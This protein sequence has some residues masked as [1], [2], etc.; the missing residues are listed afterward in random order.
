M[1]INLVTVVDIPHL[2][3]YALQELKRNFILK[4]LL[5]LAHVVH[6]YMS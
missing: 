3:Y 1:L 5:P 2:H 4:T 6:S